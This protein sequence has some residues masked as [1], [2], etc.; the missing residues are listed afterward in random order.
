MRIGSNRTW[1]SD[2]HVKVARSAD[3]SPR[4]YRCAQPAISKDWRARG[5]VVAFLVTACVAFISPSAAL[6]AGSDPHQIT[7]SFGDGSPGLQMEPVD[8]QYAT[9]ILKSLGPFAGIDQGDYVPSPVS[10]ISGSP[11]GGS[12][13]EGVSPPSTYDLRTTGKLTPVRDQG[14]YGTCWAFAAVG[15]LESG[16]MPTDPENFSEDNMVLASGFFSAGMSAASLYN[17]GGNFNMSTAYLARW[18]GPVYESDEPYGTGHVVPGLVARRHVQNVDELPSR[19][20][21]LD[22]DAIKAAVMEHGAVETSMFWTSSAYRSSTHAYYY[23]GS[24]MNHAVDI[25]G[26]DD[27]YSASNFAVHP[28]GAGAWIVRNSWGTWFGSGG[29]FYVSYYDGAFGSDGSVVVETAEP[30]TN[31]GSV[32]QYDTLGQTT[33]CGLGS[34]TAWMMNKFPITS[35]SGLRAVA[36]YART[37]GST[38][39]VYA[40]TGTLVQVTSG[41]LATAGYHTVVLPSPMVAVAGSTLSVAVKLTTPGSNYPIPVEAMYTGYSDQAVSSAGQ[42]FVSSNGTSWSDIAGFGNVCLKAFVDPVADDAVAPLTTLSAS[43]ASNTAGWNHTTVSVSLAA[44]DAGSGVRATYYRLNSAATASYAG[45]IAIL[46]QGTNTLTYWSVD[47][48]GN[49]ETSKTAIFRLDT[50]AP[51]TTADQSPPADDAGW[52]QDSVVVTLAGA[53]AG[54]GVEGTYYRL[55]S[56]EVTAYSAPISVTASGTTTLAYWTQDQAGNVESAQTTEIKIDRTA[57]IVSINSALH[58]VN[59]AAAQVSASDAVSGIALTQTSLDATSAWQSVQQVSTSVPGTHTVYARVFDQAGNSAEASAT[60]SVVR[61]VSMSRLTRPVLSPLTP[62][63]GGRARVTA[64]L[65]SGVAG[66]TAPSKV[67]LFYRETKTITRQVHGA[68]KL[69]RV[70]YW[71]RIGAHTMA[72]NSPGNLTWSGRFAYRGTWKMYVTYAG[73]AFDTHAT[74]T[75]TYFEVK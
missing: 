50:V 13:L 27:S 53:D 62:K 74:S 60:F 55:G 8:T 7:P 65:S 9:Y 46:T 35:A 32:L 64:R 23:S 47:A 72:A 70:M 29:Y 66:L 16:L 6:A 30:T 61:V 57:P 34:P 26:W 38:Y 4:A 51:T 21:P 73:S 31:Y 17:Y 69:V 33:S 41:T 68:K 40:G 63:R 45:P 20:G 10:A 37:P 43:P 44:S 71:R 56:G 75:T 49:V 54:S 58:Y 11:S 24:G 2:R 28:A 12:G 48:A 42:S 18:A 1:G 15:S 36:F 25:V 14:A 5:L 3:A 52:N 19:S 67:Y 39:E 22:N 59:V